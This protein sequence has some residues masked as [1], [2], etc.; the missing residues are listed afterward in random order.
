MCRGRR[1]RR[2]EG[3]G[4]EI[5]SSPFLQP[6]SLCPQALILLMCSGDVG[7]KEL[8]TLNLGALL[9][10]LTSF[11]LLLPLLLAGL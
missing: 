3:Q 4:K 7:E 9:L 5:F 1:G 8:E 11:H 2:K 6:I 10:P